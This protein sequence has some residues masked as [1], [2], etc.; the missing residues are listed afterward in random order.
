MGTNRAEP[1][2]PLRLA[3]TDPRPRAVVKIGGRMGTFDALRLP[4][5]LECLDLDAP[6]DELA[7]YARTELVRLAVH[8][9]RKWL[10]RWLAN[11]EL[12]ELGGV[13]NTVID[14]CRYALD[15]AAHRLDEQAVDR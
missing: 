4:R 15:Q 10:A 7:Q 3:P 5:T 13:W 14:A 12:L 8:R 9:D 6:T 1:T 11:A 2:V